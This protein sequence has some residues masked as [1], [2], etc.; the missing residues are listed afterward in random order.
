MLTAII[1]LIVVGLLLIFAE[2]LVPGGVLGALGAAGLLAAVVLSYIEYGFNVGSI[3]LVVVA[4]ISVISVVVGLQIFPKTPL[5]KKLQL[6]QAIDSA[7]DH[8]D[9]T[10]LVG[11]SGEAITSLR[12]AGAALIDGSRVD[13]VSQGGLIDAGAAVTVIHTEGARV[14]VRQ[15]DSED[16]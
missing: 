13:V 10:L 7:E 9:F 6:N 14:V 2:V 8:P 5:G 15:V 11:K 3:M 12:P 4:M 16:A 1:I